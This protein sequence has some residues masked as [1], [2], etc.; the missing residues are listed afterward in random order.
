VNIHELILANRSYRRFDEN[1]PI[2]HENIMSWLDSARLTMSSVNMQPIKYYISASPE[3]NAKIRPYTYWAR[4]LKDY[5]GPKDGENPTAY[6]FVCVDTSV[7]NATPE[8]FAKDIGIVSQTIMLSAVEDGFGGCMI[9]NFDKQ[10]LHELFD[11]PE[12]IVITLVLALGK[13]DEKI[14]IETLEM[15]SLPLIIVHPMECT[16]FPSANWKI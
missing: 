15:V 3:T 5:D 14:V 1:V 6:I 12:N 2:T 11:L 13:P 16:M 10:K 4:L 7:N 9:G 8:R